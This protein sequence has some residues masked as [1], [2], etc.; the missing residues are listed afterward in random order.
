MSQCLIRIPGRDEERGKSN[1][2][3]TV[4]CAEIANEMV[5][6]LGWFQVAEC[7]QCDIFDSVDELLAGFRHGAGNNEPTCQ[8]VF[9]NGGGPKLLV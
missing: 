3:V 6:R 8:S 9:Q 5:Q 7:T 1:A 4:P 2:L